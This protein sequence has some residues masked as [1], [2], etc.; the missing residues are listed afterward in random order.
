M[1]YVTVYVRYYVVGQNF[2][3]YQKLSNKE[4]WTPNWL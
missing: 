3:L 4:K 1:I 2:Y